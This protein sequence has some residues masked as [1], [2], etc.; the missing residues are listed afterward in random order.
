MVHARKFSRQLDG[1]LPTHNQPQGPPQIIISDSEDPHKPIYFKTLDW[2]D[3]FINS[4]QASYIKTSTSAQN[5]LKKIKKL[6]TR[7]KLLLALL[8]LLF[9]V[10]LIGVVGGLHLDILKGDQSPYKRLHYATHNTGPKFN[11][12]REKVV[13]REE[14]IPVPAIELTPKKVTPVVR[15]EGK[16]AKRDELPVK[17]LAPRKMIPRPFGKEADLDDH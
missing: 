1:T 17:G 10:S 9:L 3:S 6:S 11:H 13:K 5:L 15:G 4:I 16:K 7:S 8:C 12:N 2:K 14:P